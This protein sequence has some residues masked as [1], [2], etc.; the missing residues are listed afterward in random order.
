MPEMATGLC[1]LFFLPKRG[2][3]EWEGEGGR[4]GRGSAEGGE[5]GHSCH[6]SEP[7]SLSRARLC[8]KRPQRPAQPRLQ[9]R[10][11]PSLSER[12]GLPQPP[13]SHPPEAN[14][15]AQGLAGPQS[16]GPSGRVDY[17]SRSL[18][19]NLFDRGRLESSFPLIIC[20]FS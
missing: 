10:D 14:Y 20:I 8:G 18:P 7:Y 13:A 17:D 11:P 5:E 9:P 19:C 1:C 15:S 2:P 12:A 6:P 4:V 3:R 16:E